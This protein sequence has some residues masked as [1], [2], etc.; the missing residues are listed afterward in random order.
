MIDWMSG[1]ASGWLRLGHH[2][3]QAIRYADNGYWVVAGLK[4]TPHGH[5]V[6]IVH[7]TYGHYP[8]GYWGH[9]GVTPGK[10]ATGINYSW[11]HQDLPRV[12]YF[13]HRIP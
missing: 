12:E 3:S 1:A 13:A 10:Q 5:V 9:L 2:T 8:L 4:A 6:V 7:G 11:T